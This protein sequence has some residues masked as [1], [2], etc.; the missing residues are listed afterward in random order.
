MSSLKLKIKGKFIL[1]FAALM[2][3]LSVAIGMF[4]F[5]LTKNRVLMQTEEQ[6]Q[7]MISLIKQVVPADKVSSFLQN[8]DLDEYDE[9]YSG[10]REIKEAYKPQYLYL[11]IP[12]E[13]GDRMHMIF[14]ISADGDDPADHDSLGSIV[15]DE[16]G[17]H[18]RLLSY[19]S[20][21]AA[22]SSVVTS[23][24]EYGYVMSDYG[25]LTGSD[26][27]NVAVIGVDMGMEQIVDEIR[28]QTFSMILVTVLII[29]LFCVLCLITVNGQI[30]KP[31]KNLAHHMG[32]FDKDKSDFEMN[33]FTVHTND[34]IE[35]MASSYNSM[36][37]DLHQYVENLRAVT[38]ERER[39]ATELNV[40]TQIQASML[41]SIFPPFPSRKEFD[42][43]ATMQPAKEV[44][45]DFYDFFMVDDDHLAV[46][47]A[48]VSGKGVPAAL[49]MVIA[50]TLI[51]NSL[52]EGGKPAD[53]FTSVNAQLCENNEAG[54][55]VTAWMAVYE[56]STGKLTF[57]N[58][59]HNPPL[60]KRKDGSFEYLKSR[61]GFVLA[62]MGGMKYRDNENF[63]AAGDILY[64][65]T[66]G[67]TEATSVDEQLF[68]EDRLKAVLD[69]NADVSLTQLLHMVKG[70]I[71][72]FVNG[73]EQFDDITML[74]LKISDRS[75][76]D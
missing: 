35:L 2:V 17:L 44:G 37:N 31:I 57:V 73:A 36:A 38:A 67:V 11:F 39:I 26:G 16:S 55:F 1:M 43:F 27:K 70:D 47:I 52:Q 51:K 24:K 5:V 64:L 9:I 30:V 4:S 75:A 58:A 3:C 59:G 46:V 33:S 74:A 53:V 72:L 23:T 68:G 28:T 62:G 71:D 40:A 20:G 10:L 12:L 66:D 48:D 29:V 14:D 15:P 8:D 32:Q 69:K 42:I 13:S 41:P 19:F 49:F 45:G 25:L 7:N 6:C 76:A 61:A 50:K 54:M 65:Y 60:I 34:E 22:M 56:I 63:L 18:S 21:A